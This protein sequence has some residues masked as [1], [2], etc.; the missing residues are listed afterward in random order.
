MA[1]RGKAN[2]SKSQSSYVAELRLEPKSDSIMEGLDS[3]C[4]LR[5][6][7]WSLCV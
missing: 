5:L 3:Y 2:G 4:M 6:I 7:G 1:Q